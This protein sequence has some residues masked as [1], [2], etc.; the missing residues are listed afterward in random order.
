VVAQQGQV[1]GALRDA[2]TKHF[3]ASPPPSTPLENDGEPEALPA[4]TQDVRV[5]QTLD[6]AG[7]VVSEVDEVDVVTP[8]GLDP[9]PVASNDSAAPVPASMAP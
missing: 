4:Q 1:A 7:N 6:E 5:V 8:S 2:I 9:S 3:G